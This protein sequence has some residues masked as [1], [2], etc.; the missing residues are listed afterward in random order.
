MPGKDKTVK[1]GKSKNALQS[2]WAE[3]VAAAESGERLNADASN[4]PKGGK[5]TISSNYIPPKAK[6]AR[7]VDEDDLPKQKGKGGKKK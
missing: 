7:T 4:T 3:A 6:G 2:E 5:N 1:A